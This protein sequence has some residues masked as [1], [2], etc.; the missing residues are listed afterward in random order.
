MNEVLAVGIALSAGIAVGAVVKSFKVP[1]VAGY[2]I[3]GLILGGTLKLIDGPMLDRLGPVNDLAL[4]LIAFGIGGELSIKVLRRLGKSI[5]SIA[6]FEATMAFVLVTGALLALGQPLHLALLLGAVSSATAPAATV[7]VLNEYKA[8][9]PLA[10]TLRGVVAIDDAIC[11]MIY[12][13]AAALAKLVLSGS[14]DF[15]I[16]KVLLVPLEEIALSIILG[17]LAGT[18]LTYIARTRVARSQMLPTVLAVVMI[19]QGLSLRFGLSPLLANMAAGFAVANISQSQ[20]VFSV[21]EGFQGPIFVTFFVLAGSRLDIGLLPRIGIVG[22]VYIIARFL[23]KYFGA[24]AGARLSNAAPQ[25]QR[26]VGLGLLSQIGVAVGLAVT[27]SREFSDPTIGRLVVTVLL[28]TTVFTEIIGPVCTRMAVLRAGEVPAGEAA[29]VAHPA[30]T[31]AYRQGA[32]D[33]L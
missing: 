33:G 21:L 2:V 1:A 11:L 22:T 12:A 32:G 16:G 17:A 23:G 9:G 30:G 24:F 28:A 4:G 6:F 31:L 18:C 10:T 8:K 3:A 29:A 20:S 27:I 25:V 26:Y 13:V 14:H 7:M 5:L 19:T 15:G